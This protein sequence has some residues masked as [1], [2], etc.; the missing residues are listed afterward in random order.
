MSESKKQ[1]VESQEDFIYGV[2]GLGN[3]LGVSHVTAAKLRKLVPSYQ[4]GRTIRFKKDEV[5]K[6]IAKNPQIV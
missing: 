4:F 6:A 3:F 1:P 2:K 5:L